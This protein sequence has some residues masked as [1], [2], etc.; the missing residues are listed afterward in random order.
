MVTTETLTM[1][2]IADLKAVSTGKLR[3]DCIRAESS[4]HTLRI[5]PTL[6]RIA[7]AINARAKAGR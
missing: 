5:W 3:A 2:Q 4:R 6:Q 7:E 1:G